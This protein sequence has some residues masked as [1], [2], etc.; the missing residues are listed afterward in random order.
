MIFVLVA[1]D[2]ISEKI[3]IFIASQLERVAKDRENELKT[4]PHLPHWA[5]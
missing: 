4:I 3:L 2:E 5:C 1:S